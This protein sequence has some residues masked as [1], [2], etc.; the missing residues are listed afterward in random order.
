[1]QDDVTG[2]GEG[3]HQGFSFNASNASCGLQAPGNLVRR[4]RYVEFLQCG[5]DID[6]RDDAEVFSSKRVRYMFFHLLRENG[7][8]AVKL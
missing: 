5:L 3:R 8:V 2:K 7:N 6:F 4:V 1:M